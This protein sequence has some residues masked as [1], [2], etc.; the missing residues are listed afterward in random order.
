MG[1]TF[2]ADV[3]ARLDMFPGVGSWEPLSLVP[4]APRGV[5]ALGTDF[6]LGCASRKDH[7]RIFRLLLAT[8]QEPSL[9]EFQALNDAPRYDAS[10]RLIMRRRDEIASHLHLVPRSV[11]FG[12]VE[13]STMDLKHLATLPEYRSRGLARELVTAALEE[14]RRAGIVVATVSSRHPNLFQRMGWFACGTFSRTTVDARRFLAHD[15][16]QAAPAPSFAARPT[17]P[18]SIQVWRRNEMDE[19][20]ALYDSIAKGSFGRTVRLESDWRWLI[21]RQA[22]DH[23]YVATQMPTRGGMAVD[24]APRAGIVGYAIVRGE[25]IVEIVA[26]GNDRRIQRLLISRVCRDAMENS[27]S[28]VEVHAPP[29]DTIHSLLV[30]AGG[31]QVH[32]ASDASRQLLAQVTH[33]QTLLNCLRPLLKARATEA[34]WG[35]PLTLGLVHP[36]GR[37]NITLGSRS[38][39]ISPGRETEYSVTTSTSTLSQMLLGHGSARQ[40]FECG[41]ARASNELARQAAEMLFPALPLWRPTFDDLPA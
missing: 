28:R 21:S 15:Q 16:G 34:H 10:D 33:P 41:A 32:A 27:R 17:A 6:E 37:T 7:A 19:L 5:P 14:M 26:Q 23:I 35:S 2:R 8:F 22:Y 3:A 13:L 4:E 11:W 25:Q 1:A 9:A 30:E 24:P 40:A 36:N 29:D 20:S 39:T 38:V 12:D 31:T 18:L